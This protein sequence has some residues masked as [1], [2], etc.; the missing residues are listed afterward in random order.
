MKFLVSLFHI[1]KYLVFKKKKRV[2]FFEN[3]FI[4]NHILKNMNKNDYEKSLALFIYKTDISKKFKNKLLIE[5]RFLIE[6]FFLFILKCKYLYSS[7]PDLDNSIFKR[8]IIFKIK[9]FYIQHS[10]I[11]LTMAY[12]PNAFIFFDAVHVL[13]MFQYSEI[14]QINNIYKKKIKPFIINKIKTNESKINN[15]KKKILIA[16]TWGTNFFEENFINSLNS[17]LKN[18]FDL[19]LRPHYMSIAKK[20]IK[21]EDYSKLIN[22]AVK[23]FDL[24]EYDYLITDSSGIMF[25]FFFT[26]KKKIIFIETKKKINNP[27]Y[28]KYGIVPIE[29]YA[30][31]KIG[32][33]FKKNQIIDIKNYIIHSNDNTSSEI[34]SFKKLFFF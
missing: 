10:N 21:L 30:K 7:T 15:K 5:N 18:D 19:F 2:F 17:L 26:N 31:N 29:E 27:D 12:G 28:K 11:S 22:L 3:K 20:K 9:Y 1:I 25:E 32:K 24:N 13:N 8:S 23:N 34:L 16:P 4:E 6:F 33:I 14:L